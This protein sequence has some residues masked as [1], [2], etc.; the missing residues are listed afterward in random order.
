LRDS[1]RRSLR[2]KRKRKNEKEG[3]SGEV[4][5]HDERSWS[6]VA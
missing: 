1:L 2:K 4:P 6:S 5:I 3:E